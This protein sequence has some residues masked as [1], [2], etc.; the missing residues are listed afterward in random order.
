MEVLPLSAKIITMGNMKGGVAKT[1]TCSI[2]AY[3][4]SEKYRCL[5]C[6]FDSQGNLTEMLTLKPIRE[7]RQQG[8]GGCLAAV[9]EGDPRPHILRLNDNLHLLPANEEMGL[10]SRWLHSD[11][12]D[13][14]TNYAIKNM[15]S[16]IKDNYDYILLDTPPT[17]SELA[18]NV[19]AASDGV[20]VLYETGQFCYSAVTSYLETIQAVKTGYP[21]MAP[22]NPSLKTLGILCSM[23]DLRRGDNKEFLALAQQTYPNCCFSTVITRKAATGR[24]P[25]AGFFNNPELTQAVD[26]FRPYIKELIARVKAS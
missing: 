24:L 17:L 16:V 20:V 3:L 5:V 18:I 9:Q 22:I 4:L 21:G 23:L 2:T 1:T 7:F 26:Q 19:L 12:S 15:L 11:Y 10:F 14:N 8:L 6:D 13:Q 25:F